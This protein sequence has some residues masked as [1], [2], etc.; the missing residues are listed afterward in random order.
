MPTSLVAT[1]HLTTGWEPDVPV[2]YTVLRQFALNSADRNEHLVTSMGGAWHRWEDAVTADL[3]SP[4][5]F[6]NQAIL[7]RPVTEADANDLVRRVQ[8][9]FSRGHVIF[10]AW[11]TPDLRPY[12]YCLVGHPPFMVRPPGGSAPVRPAELSVVEVTDAAS[13]EACERVF[14]EGYPVPEVQPFEP[15]QLFDTRVLGGIARMWVGAVDGH[16]VATA[17]AIA[18]RGIVAVENVATLA[19]ARGHGY[20]AALTATAALSTPDRPSVLIASDDGRPVY[21]RL[22]FVPMSRFTLWAAQ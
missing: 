4:A 7:L 18:S 1:D 13:M 17:M 8:G 22:G 19:Q 6:G 15:G 11:P 14:V 21:E 5:A 10:S 20:G 12:G 16:P 9:G 3:G 2:D